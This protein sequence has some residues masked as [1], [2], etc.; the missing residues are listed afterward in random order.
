[1]NTCFDVANY[2]LRSQNEDIGENI[3]NM[4]L[5]KLVYYAQG[6]YLAMKDEPLFNEPIQAWD[7]GPVCDPLFQK[8]KTYGSNPIPL[9]YDIN[10]LEL[11]DKESLEILNMVNKH[12]GQ[13]SAWKLSD[14]THKEP[15]WIL[16]Y[17]KGR[18][19][20]SHDTMREYF[21]TQI[22]DDEE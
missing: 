11:F 6:I 15:P 9:D 19:V 14:M 7:Y 5:Q 1:M 22:E 18:G 12:Y 4:K 13:Y 10:I 21:K 8:Y 2:F 20:I 3:S 16:A 17:S